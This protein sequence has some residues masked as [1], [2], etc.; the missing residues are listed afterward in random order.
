MK[1]LT[2]RSL[3]VIALIIFILS[4]ILYLFSPDYYS[5]I[6]CNILFILYLFSSIFVIH[7][8]LINKNYFN[9]HVLFL[10]SFFFVNFIYPVF[11]YPVSPYYFPVYKYKFNPDIITK[12]TALALLG[13]ASYNLGVI[14]LIRKRDFSNSAIN[15]NFKTLQI[16]LYSLLYISF[17]ILLLFGGIGL[18]KGR[19]HSTAKVPPGLILIFQI[20]LGLSIMIALYV[21]SYKG[22]TIDFINKFNKPL[23]P[24]IIMF[25]LMFLVAGDRGPIIQIVLISIVSFT[26]FIKPI[27]I[28]SFI[29]IVL[30]GMLFLTI[31]AY[32]RIQGG[33]DP[34]DPGISVSK[35]LKVF[36]LNSFYDI[37]MD[38]IVNNR[39]LYTGYEYVNTHGFNYGMSMSFQLL[40][41]FP[42]LPSL[43][44]HLIYK[45][46]PDDIT[47]ARILTRDSKASYGLGTNIIIDLYMGF[48][49]IGVVFFMFLLGLIATTFQ[50]RAHFSDNFSYKIAYV[51]LVSLAV[52][53]PRSTVMDPLRPII[54]A[55]ILFKSI[56]GLRLLLLQLSRKNELS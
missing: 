5:Y 27:R 50:W 23:L 8:S 56:Q 16:I 4:V 12:A 17:F 34:S 48:G 52:Y 26:L 20:I 13:A 10:I 39:N 24:I 33:K 25:F 41:P 36:E 1:T 14:L 37:G 6:Y 7:H 45:S 55:I 15:T 44:S 30:A 2:K 9:F 51:F 29:T 49:V 28:K 22:T 42:F 11:I 38:L 35:G 53:L 54:W 32:A 3:V 31:I 43:F 47:S 40:A 18:I 21:K 46:K 19:F